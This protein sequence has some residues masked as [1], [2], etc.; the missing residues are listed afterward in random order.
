MSRRLTPRR[1]RVVHECMQ[2]LLLLLLLR[3][4]FFRKPT[5]PSTR[6]QQPSIR[7]PTEAAAS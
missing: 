2:L 5:R 7:S 3:L 4:A 1:A 6:R